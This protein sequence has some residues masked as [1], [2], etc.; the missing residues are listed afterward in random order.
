MDIHWHTI[1]SMILPNNT[2]V[3]LATIESDM[4]NGKKRYYIDTVKFNIETREFTGKS[5][6]NPKHNDHVVAWIDFNDI[7]YR[8]TEGDK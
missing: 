6:D 2:R 8:P 4:K 7:T 1:E 3:V 5:L